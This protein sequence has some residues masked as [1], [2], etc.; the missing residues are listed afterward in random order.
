MERIR[1]VTS[2]EI[3]LIGFLYGKKS[4]KS[5]NLLFPGVDGNIIT[6]EFIEILGK[7][8]PS[9]NHNFLCCHHRGSFQIISSNPL[10]S[11]ML[12][13]T[14]GSAF[15][16]FDASIY[17]IDAW[18]EY[19]IDNGANSINI[20]GHSHGCNKI[21]YYLS[22]CHKYDR[23]INKIILISPLD[24]YTRMNERKEIKELYDKA[25]YEINSKNSGDFICCGFFYKSPES[26][27]DMMDNHNINNFPMMS[28]TNNDF[29]ALN[30]ISK[31]KYIIYGGDEY[32][33]TKNFNIKR[34]HIDNNVK[35]MNI[36][37][38]ASH[39][40]QGKELELSNLIK[41]IVV[42]E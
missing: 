31:P 17:D 39:I 33:Y 26:F 30:Q 4:C 11:K 40:Y 38:G 10:S 14:I 20:I 21:I 36:I 1:V 24:L 29:S 23:F 13:K 8:I 35:E 37:D 22:N 2:D 34:K 3:N 19:A 5:W 41:S 32:K 42:K 9:V 6:N 12:G 7:N 25:Y 28:K 15:E 27:L 16:K 18:L